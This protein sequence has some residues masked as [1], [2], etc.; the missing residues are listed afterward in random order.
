M[1][2]KKAEKAASG[3]AKKATRAAAGTP[4]KSS[5]K[6]KAA[7]TKKTAAAAGAA[8]EKA[9]TAAGKYEKNVQPKLGLIECWARD[10]VI[11]KDIAKRLGVA[12]ST[13]RIYVKAQSALSA[14]LKK[15]KEV[16]DYEVENALLERAKGG[17]RVLRRPF[18]LK[19]VTFLD[20]KK[21]KE[22]EQ[23]EY[24][25]YEEYT[26]P[27]TGAAIFWLKNRKPENWRDKPPELSDGTGEGGVIHI[28]E[29][30][31]PD[32]GGNA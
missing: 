6:T 3:A 21:V 26:P 27:D 13:F 32:G 1:V 28:P 24:A 25:D 22:E 15:G 16:V 31:I 19:R 10:G 17:V 18:K 7:A 8:A 20:G 23:I 11:D 4:K 14:A 9:I 29:V 2:A 5:K 12:Y 30:V